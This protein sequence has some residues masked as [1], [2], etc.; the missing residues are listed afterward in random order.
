MDST[1][2]AVL[3]PYKRGKPSGLFRAFYPDGSLLIR[4]V[5]G[6]GSLHGDWTEYD[7]DG[8]ITVKG[9]YRDGLRDGKW[10]FRRDGIRGKYKNGLKHGKWKYYNGKTITRVEKYYKGNPRTGG[11]FRFNNR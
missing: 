7:E 9:Q 5:Y 6:W 4:A 8:I 1:K 3:L 10:V 2:I 11:T